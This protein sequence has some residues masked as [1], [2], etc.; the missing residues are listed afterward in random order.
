VI[1]FSAVGKDLKDGKVVFLPIWKYDESS[2][3]D[4]PRW[5]KLGDINSATE[6][7]HE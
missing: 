2:P 1:S 4:A 3:V 6:P 7:E 5:T